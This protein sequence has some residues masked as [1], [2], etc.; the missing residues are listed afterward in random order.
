MARFT[1]KLQAAF[2]RFC[3]AESSARRALGAAEAVLAAERAALNEL[4]T[5]AHV[6]RELLRGAGNV[7]ALAEIDRRI[8]ALDKA[9][10]GRK[11][12]IAAALRRR[13]EARTELELAV[14]RRSALERHRE[15]ALAKHLQAGE[16]R[17][18]AELDEFNAHAHGLR[19][20]RASPF[21]N[22]ALS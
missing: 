17:E 12:L 11:G 13:A 10:S 7:C 8:I 21:H 19:I 18:A 16:L 15:R 1:Y 5:K 9:Q 22:R 20:I 3:D 14:R 4:E 2:E 6:A